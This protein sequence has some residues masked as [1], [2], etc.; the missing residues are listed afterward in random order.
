MNKTKAWFLAGAVLTAT[1]LVL[2]M[3]LH[4]DGE[5]RGRFGRRAGAHELFASGAPII[6]IALKHKDELKLTADQ[7]A[8]LEKTRTHYQNQVQP[9]HQQLRTLEG[10]V[11]KLTQETPANLVQVK[12]KI[13]E[14]EKIRSE[15]RY[16]RIEALE[17]GKSILSAEQREQLKNMF[18]S[19]RGQHMRPQAQPS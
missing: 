6:S 14:S 9:M 19:H 15:L 12:L 13:Q 10:E 5:G 16:L 11:A 7:V 2:P 4:A 18:A 1:A 3:V 17:N 8:N